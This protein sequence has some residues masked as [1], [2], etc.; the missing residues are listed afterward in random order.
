MQSTSRFSILSPK[1]FNVR[2]GNRQGRLFV[3]FGGSGANDRKSFEFRE[4]GLYTIIC[5][6]SDHASIHLVNQ[7]DAERYFYL[8]SKIQIVGKFMRTRN[9]K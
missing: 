2:R 7:K 3:R 9:P 5:Y 6:I 4:R 1:C 8:N